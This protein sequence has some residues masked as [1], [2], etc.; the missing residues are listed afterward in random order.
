MVKAGGWE[1]VS[2][3]S[4]PIGTLPSLRRGRCQEICTLPRTLQSIGKSS[5]ERKEY[6][7]VTL[8]QGSGC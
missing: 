1:V 4:G 6:W 7:E 5:M 8:D 2:C 3:V